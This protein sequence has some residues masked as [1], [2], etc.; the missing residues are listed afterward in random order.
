LIIHHA[1]KY[2]KRAIKSNG[3][4]YDIYTKNPFTENVLNSLGGLAID[5]FVPW[6]FVLHDR[7]W[8]LV[9]TFGRPNSSKSD[10][11]PDRDF[12]DDFCNIQILGLKANI[13]WEKPKKTEKNKKEDS[14]LTPIFRTHLKKVGVSF[15]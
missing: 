12:L 1:K 5:H 4:I 9:P 14:E 8:N 2:W 13:D 7:L 11:L 15:L 10:N 3:Q 6:R